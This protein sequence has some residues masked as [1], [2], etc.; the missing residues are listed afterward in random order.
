[1][2]ACAPE[3]PPLKAALAIF[4]KTP[5]LSPIKTRLAHTIGATAADEF[6]RLAI[7]AIAAVARSTVAAGV[8]LKPY[9]AVAERAALADPDWREFPTLWQGI[10][11]LGDRLEHV[12]AELRAR[13]ERVL[14]IGADAPQISSADF[15]AALTA[16]RNPATPFTVGRAADG[17]FWLLGSRAEIPRRV[18]QAAHYSN[19]RTADELSA[20]LGALGNI[21]W[22]SQLTDVDTADDLPCLL[23]ELAALTAPLPEQGA[24]HAW[25]KNLRA[26]SERQSR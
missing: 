1:M 12:H 8:E 16:L 9:W 2:V 25:I 20:A 5:G 10:G 18:W 24:V 19:A 4:V 26:T 13:H 6:Y 15:A 11:E 21:A 7:S 17:G 22:L 23:R 14:L 3:G